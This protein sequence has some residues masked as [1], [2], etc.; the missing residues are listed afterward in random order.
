MTLYDVFGAVPESEGGPISD[1]GVNSD[2]RRLMKVGLFRLDVR[3]P[4]HLAPLLGFIRDELAEI[5]GRA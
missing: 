1:I 2:I 3:R 5:T 4:D